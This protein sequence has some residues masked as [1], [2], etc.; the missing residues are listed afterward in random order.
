MSNNVQLSALDIN[1][2]PVGL[3]FLPSIFHSVRIPQSLITRPVTLCPSAGQILQHQ[4]HCEPIPTHPQKNHSQVLI[5]HHICHKHDYSIHAVQCFLFSLQC[6]RTPWRET[7][8][9]CLA[10]WPADK[11]NWLNGTTV[12]TGLSWPGTNA[13]NSDNEKFQTVKGVLVFG[14]LSS[15]L[16]NKQ[17]A[18]IVSTFSHL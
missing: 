2:Q 17:C 14:F 15:V 10:M 7:I 16:M 3:E 18:S 5:Q 4:R 11:D 9:P 8:W 1:T 6:E 12:F 13:M